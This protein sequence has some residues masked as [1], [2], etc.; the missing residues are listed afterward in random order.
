MKYSVVK[1][2]CCSLLVL[3]ARLSY[4]QDSI[5]Y[6]DA[7]TL[8]L[9]GKAKITDS[10]YQRIDSMEAKDMPQAVKG[11]AK[12]SAG[13]AILFETNS[14]SIRAKWSL[15]KEVYLHNMTP[16]AHSGLDL[17][18]YKAGK[19]QFVSIGRVAPGISQNQLIVQ[20]MD[21]TVKQFM[22]Y[23]PL[24][25]GISQLQIGIQNTATINKPAQPAINIAKRIVVYGSSVVQGA[26]ASRAGMAYPAMLQR[27]TG[28]DVINL[29][30]SGSAKME[31]PLAKYLATVPADC[32]VLDCI[33]N[34][35][36]EEISERSYP[37]IKYL[38]EQ[39][40]AIPIVMVETIFRQN[41]LWDQQVGNTVKRQNEAIRKTYERLRKEGV[42]NIY[43]LESDK[44]IGDDHE[45]TIDGIHLT[46]LGFTRIADAILP[47]IKKALA[48]K[49]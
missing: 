22:L 13:I 37:F 15:P 36:P 26:S 38:H 1:I 48:E 35:S 42:K 24:Y 23:L 21:N 27:R 8:M 46:D 30:F 3:A 5:K 49:K 6:V 45:A 43:Y 25:N 17:Y 20:N 18:C 14:R 10:I 44:L 7:A 34:P 32:Y 40:P 39:Q 11:L 4:S 33:P 31:M 16:D 19:W 41:G 2:I 47:V 12:Q 9:I 29:G 28:Y